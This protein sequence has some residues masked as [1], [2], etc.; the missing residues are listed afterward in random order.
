MSDDPFTM[1]MPSSIAL[2]A[3]SSSDQTRSLGFDATI[4]LQDNTQLTAGYTRSNLVLNDDTF[5]F[6]E[7]R[8]GAGTDPLN[9]IAASVLLA[10]LGNG[11]DT[12]EFTGN[13]ELMWSPG[14]FILTVTPGYGAIQTSNRANIFNEETD[15]KFHQTSVAA[16]AEW[17]FAKNFSIRAI[18]ASYSYD[19][20]LSYLNKAALFSQTFNVEVIPPSSQQLLTT[21]P[22]SQY[23][24]GLNF[25]KSIWSLGIEAVQTKTFVDDDIETS[26]KLSGTYKLAKAWSLVAA[27]GQLPSFES[28]TTTTFRGTIIHTW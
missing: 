28:D 2:S 17:F 16:T 22:S 25:S 20:N 11:S 3:A 18:G 13:L 12:N 9:D 5:A 6:N 21:L 4:S 7:V 1:H 10:N 26:L 8:V 24:V 19:N 23:G 14:D 27:F 15:I